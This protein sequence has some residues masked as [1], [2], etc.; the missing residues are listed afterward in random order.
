LYLLVLKRPGISFRKPLGLLLLLEI[1]ILHVIS[2]LSMT[3]LPIF[4]RVNTK[5]GGAIDFEMPFEMWRFHPDPSVLTDVAVTFFDARNPTAEYDFKVIPLE[6]G[7]NFWGTNTDI[8]KGSNIGAGD[9]IAIIG[10]FRSHHGVDRNIPIVRTGNIATMSEEQVSTE[11]CGYT[12]AYLVEARSIAGLS[13]SPVLVVR[14]PMV[15]I[16]NS[17]DPRQFTARRYFLLGLMHGHFDVKNLK[18]DM[19][20]DDA[21]AVGGGINTGIGIVI[22]CGKILDAI[23]QPEFVELRTMMI[24]QKRK[25]SGAKA[26]VISDDAAPQPTTDANPNHLEDFKRLAGA[27]ARKQKPAE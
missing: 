21:G 8:I 17:L 9:E 6:Q 18:E 14:G 15:E 4:V 10:L 7:P 16:P 24:E 19:V 11:Y 5:N 25:E 26:D 13:G 12:D 1:V 20:S 22:P 23:D 27:A 3:G 2:Q